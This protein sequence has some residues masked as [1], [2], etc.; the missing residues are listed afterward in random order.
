MP[1]DNTI[2]QLIETGIHEEILQQ[3]RPF[4]RLMNQYQS[5]IMEMETKLKV[6]DS[7]FSMEYDRNPFESIKSRLKSPV[8]I[9]KKLRN[10]GL[11]I[12]VEN[13]ERNLYDVAGVRVICSFEEDIYKLMELLLRQD[14]IKLIRKKDYI[15]KPKTNG[16]RSL[17]LILE[18]PI[19]QAAGPK[20]MY[21]EVQFRT[22][23]MD[24][25]ASLDHKLR[26]KKDITNS[27]EIAAEL[28]ECA[29]AIARLDM[30]MQDIRHRIDRD[31]AESDGRHTSLT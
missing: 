2:N 28:K 1:R 9:F 29:D 3:S 14:D 21:V 30:K 11:D 24:F 7:E 15:R 16:Y 20:K 25:W 13:I 10:K 18:I 6:L 12:T 27:E 22:I 5:A 31:N 23:A 19:F 17:H 26:Y 4:V 8:S